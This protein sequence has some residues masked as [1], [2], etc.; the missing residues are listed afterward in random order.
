MRRLL[1]SCLLSLVIVSTGAIAADAKPVLL[2]VP[3]AFPTTLPGLGTTMKWVADRIELV[4]QG[5]VKMKL[6]E[7]SKLVAPFETLDA[8]STGKVNAGYTAAG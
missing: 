6:Y 7:P 8:V 4:S 2:K 3:V 1:V 5:S